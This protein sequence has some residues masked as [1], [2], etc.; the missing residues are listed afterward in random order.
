MSGDL[1]RLS[2]AHEA[3]I[4]RPGFGLT[5]DFPRQEYVERVRRARASM[6]EHELD[7]LVITSSG[8][9]SWFTSHLEPHEWHDKCSARAAWYILTASR[10]GTSY[11]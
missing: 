4:N 10:D 6:A 1:R 5:P 7:A 9:G 2:A 3:W 11:L 8:V